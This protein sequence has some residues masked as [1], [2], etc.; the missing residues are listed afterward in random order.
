M[1]IEQVIEFELREPGSPG[2]RRSQEVRRYRPNWNVIYDKTVAKKPIVSLVSSSFTIFCVHC[3]L[4]AFVKNIDN[5]GPHA[6]LNLIFANQFKCI[7]RKK[8]RDLVLKFAIP[9][10]HLTFLW[11]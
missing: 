1:L 2:H 4:L 5:Q 9:S 7:T 6:P 10:L 3:F 11:T 8:L